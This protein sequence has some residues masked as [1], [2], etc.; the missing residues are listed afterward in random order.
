MVEQ[1]RTEIMTL[2]HDGGPGAARAA[3][4]AVAEEYKRRFRQE[5]VLRERVTTCALF[6]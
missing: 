4:S 3:V 5:A 1:E 6:E 2:L